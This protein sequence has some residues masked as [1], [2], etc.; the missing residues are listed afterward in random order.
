[1]KPE[2]ILQ[3]LR[4]NTQVKKDGYGKIIQAIKT[5]KL[6]KQI[7]KEINPL[8]LSPNIKESDIKKMLT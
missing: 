7:L 8:L 3:A 2:Q 1:M 4:K 5:L 6:E